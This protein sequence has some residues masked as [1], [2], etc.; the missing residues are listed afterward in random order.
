MKAAVERT[1]TGRELA[2]G[3]GVEQLLLGEPAVLVD[4]VTFEKGD[5]DVA[6]AVE[7]AS[8]LKEEEAERAEGQGGGGRG[9]RAGPP[10]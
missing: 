1:G 9:H 7:D 8:D 5:E 10:T 3:D 6:A 4:E 2:D